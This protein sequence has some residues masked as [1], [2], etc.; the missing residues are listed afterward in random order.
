MSF[1]NRDGC[2]VWLEA[3]P[4][5]GLALPFPSSSRGFGIAS[6]Q[7]SHPDAY[8]AVQYESAMSDFRL[9]RDIHQC[10][11]DSGLVRLAVP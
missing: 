2:L 4:E 6:S 3:I 10:T 1:L 11:E 7:K 8:G 9:A 5:P